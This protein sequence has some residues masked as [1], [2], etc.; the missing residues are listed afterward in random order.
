MKVMVLLKDETGLDS[1]C[2][3]LCCQGRSK[4]FIRVVTEGP[5]PFYAYLRVRMEHLLKINATPATI[6]EVHP[7][8]SP[9]RM[10]LLTG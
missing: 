8:V 3:F 5:R 10:H 4:T 6:C 1:F 9:E 7:E 2:H